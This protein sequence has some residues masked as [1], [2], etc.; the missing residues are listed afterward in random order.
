[1]YSLNSRLFAMTFM[2]GCLVATIGC[3]MAK[4]SEFMAGTNV[5]IEREGASNQPLSANQ[6][7]QSYRWSYEEG[8]RQVKSE[9]YGLAIGSFENALKVHEDSTE[10]LFNLGACHEAIGDPLRAINFYRRVLE[11]QPDDPDCYRN[12]GTSFIKLYHREQSPAWMKMAMD[13]WKRSLELNPNQPDVRGF[14]T[15][16]PPLD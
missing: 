11:T 14:L 8:L 4:K 6:R 10:A 16:S 2:S 7:E 13:A 1:M 15:Q 3:G 9:Q 5:K 12:L